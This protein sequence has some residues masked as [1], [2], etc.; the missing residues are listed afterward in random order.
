LFEIGG[1]RFLV[2]R[3]DSRR[4]QMLKLIVLS[5]ADTRIAHAFESDDQLPE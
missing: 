2:L 1:F 5:S 3:A 4:V